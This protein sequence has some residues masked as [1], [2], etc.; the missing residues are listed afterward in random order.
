MNAI[1]ELTDEQLEAAL[2]KRKKLKQ[3][4]AKAKKKKYEEDRNQLVVSA[5]KDA[6]SLHD[7]L[8][9]L[10]EK[11]FSKLDDFMDQ[12]REYGDV[13]G[14]SQ[15]GFSLVS[16]DGNA[17]L[18]LSYQT[19]KTFDER[20][21]MAEEKLKNFLESF[22]KKRDQKSYKLITSLLERPNGKDFDDTLI[23]RLWSMEDDF[24]NKDWKESIKLF[25]ESYTPS[26]T[27]RY[28]NFYRKNDH[29]TWEN[30]QLNFSSISV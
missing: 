1:D 29:G 3:R 17:K 9:Q 28:I 30:V 13:N 10:K 23:M 25:K 27:T 26:K 20:A 22:V 16:E 14:K 15:G 24:D 18:K 19:K 21:D 5:C 11:C 2:E 8:S 12:M 6:V 7:I 4:E